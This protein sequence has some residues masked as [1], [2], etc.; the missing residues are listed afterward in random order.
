MQIFHCASAG[1]T[2]AAAAGSF[3]T[4]EQFI[5]ALRIVAQHKISDNDVGTNGDNNQA[6]HVL[7][8]KHLL[9]ARMQ[10]QFNIQEGNTTATA[11]AVSRSCANNGSLPEQY[12]KHQRPS[13]LDSYRTDLARI[14]LFVADAARSVYRSGERDPYVNVI[15]GFRLN[16]RIKLT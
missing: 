9:T 6:F 14:F 3:I 4:F 2:T 13:L 5:D 11:T 16:K 10:R 15:C 7:L 1:T 12:H 8:T